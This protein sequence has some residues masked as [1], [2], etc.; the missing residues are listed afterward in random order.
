MACDLRAKNATDA[1][2]IEL[3]KKRLG[4]TTTNMTDKYIRARKG[5][6]VKPYK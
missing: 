1:E 3:A 5:E 2:N 6:K 4:H